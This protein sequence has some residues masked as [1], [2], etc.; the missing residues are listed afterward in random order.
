VRITIFPAVAVLAVL[1]L[2]GMAAAQYIPRDPVP[3]FAIPPLIRGPQ[4]GAVPTIGTI[5]PLSLPSIGLPLPSIGLP[6]SPMFGVPQPPFVYGGTGPGRHQRS[7]SNHSDNWNR[8]RLGYSAYPGWPVMVVMT[9][10]GFYGVPQVPA[11][12]APASVPAPAP[13]GSLLLHVQPAG[14]QVFVDGYYAGTADDFDGNPG[15]LVLDT[16]AHIIELDDPSY[17]TVRFDVRIDAN[18]SI[19]YRRELTPVTP[20]IT[21]PSTAPTNSTPTPMYLIPGCY[22]GNVPPKD[23]GLPATCDP[24]RVIRL[25]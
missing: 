16:G 14:A 6:P 1:A 21:A 4:S 24:S 10:P 18:Q 11:E 23:A 12:V 13:K 15:A 19:V 5:P 8:G 20:T 9:A 7:H 25:K 3:N 2:P 17:Q 22:L